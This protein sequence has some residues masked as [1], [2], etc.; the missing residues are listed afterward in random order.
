MSI[1][2]FKTPIEKR[3]VDAFGDSA[4]ALEKAAFEIDKMLEEKGIRTAADIDAVLE[5]IKRNRKRDILN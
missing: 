4:T 2:Q 5:R 3:Q 1:D